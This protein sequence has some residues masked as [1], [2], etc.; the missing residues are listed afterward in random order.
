MHPLPALQTVA[1]ALL[2]RYLLDLWASGSQ[3]S[4]CRVVHA[5]GCGSVLAAAT[6]DQSYILLCVRVG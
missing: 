6:A 4:S 5:G 2:V 1:A 3:E